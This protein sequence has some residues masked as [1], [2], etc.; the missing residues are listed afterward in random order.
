MLSE[1]IAEM[2]KAHEFILKARPDAVDVAVPV[3]DMTALLTA[4]N[5]SEARGRVCEAW[6]NNRDAT[7]G[8]NVHDA[9]RQTHTY[10]QWQASIQE[11]DDALAALAAAEKGGAEGGG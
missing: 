9:T 6:K 7:Q 10:A 2:C 4:A 1:T 8:F 5:L 11:L 3:A